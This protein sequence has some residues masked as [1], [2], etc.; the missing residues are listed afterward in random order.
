MSEA[1]SWVKTAM[2]A[3]KLV[4]SAIWVNVARVETVGVLALCAIALFQGL[5]YRHAEQIAERMTEQQT[6]VQQV[7]AQVTESYWKRM[8]Y[9]SLARSRALITDCETM[10]RHVLWELHQVPVFFSDEE[11][12]M[13]KYSSLIGGTSQST[14]QRTESLGALLDEMRKVVDGTSGIPQVGSVAPAFSVCEA[15]AE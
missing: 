4:P 7:Q 12:V 11:D 10:P 9:S 8:T 13:E 2:S 5:G 14:A 6:Q 1:I 15:V 3:C